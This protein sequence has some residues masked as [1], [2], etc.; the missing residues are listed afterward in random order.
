[1]TRAELAERLTISVEEAGEA[2]GIGR[3]AAYAAARGGEL[4][5]VRL[6]RRLLVPTTA[7]LALL[8]A[9]TEH[10]EH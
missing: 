1:M 10:A 7:L 2:L 5:T 4:P 6:G 8:D 9:S 3:T